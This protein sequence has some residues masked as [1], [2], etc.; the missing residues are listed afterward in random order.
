MKVPFAT[1]R[2]HTLYVA[3]VSKHAKTGDSTEVTSLKVAKRG[4]RL[5]LDIVLDC[6]IQ[7]YIQL[8]CGNGTSLS[9]ALVLAAAEGYLLA[10]DRTVLIQYGGH[11]LL[12]R[13]GHDHFSSEW[14]T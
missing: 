6:E 14:V 2:R 5:C 12:Q 11:V 8:L 4:V 3:E 13:I 10:C 1:L 7:P 9:I